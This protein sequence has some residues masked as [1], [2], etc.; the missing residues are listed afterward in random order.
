VRA[1]DSDPDGDPL[2]VV[3]VT[4]PPAGGT[5]SVG[6]GG[7]NV[8]FTPAA[9]FNGS[10]NFTYTV[11]D[12]QGGTGSANV[13]VTVTAVNDAPDAV[14]D[15]AVT[16]EDAPVTVDVLG[17]DVDADGDALT[18]TGVSNPTN[19]T[20]TVV[21][22]GTAVRFTPAPGFSGT[23]GV[24]Y[25]VSDGQGG[26]DTARLTVSVGAV[27][28]APTAVEDAATT[29]EDVAVTIN[30]L[31]NDIDPDDDPLQVQ[32][33]R[34]G[35]NG[36]VTIV[37]NAGAVLYTPNPNFFGTDSFTYTVT[38]GGG[39]SAATVTVTVTPVP[40]PPVA[41]DDAA[42]TPE[43]TP[44]TIGVMA[45]DLDPDGDPISVTGVTAPANG[46]AAVNE[47]GAVTYTPNA[48]FRGTDTFTYTLTDGSGT[49]TATVTVSIEQVEVGA[50][51]V[52]VE[53]PGSAGRVDGHDVLFILRSIATQDPRA[54]V[55][56]D[57]VV[58]QTDVQLALGAMGAGQ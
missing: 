40:D 42:A 6:A 51:N 48:G 57:G 22:G 14:D 50:L 58:D 17:N 15:V 4:Q 37:N 5:A 30:V 55:N 54:D 12:G 44:V 3:S 35:T 39:N 18:I 45:N 16:S 34:N 28:D 19:G 21:A 32:S 53:A 9:N 43:Q 7:Q 26:T 11:S 47:N 36:A 24:S 31:A 56:R 49:D 25:T 10:V 41:N 46:T 23:G 29:P 27:Q 20:A 13:N 2:T 33:V 1:N 8:V 38:D 52:E